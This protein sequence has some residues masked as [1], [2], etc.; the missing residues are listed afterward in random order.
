M[1]H[2]SGSELDID[3]L[4][5]LINITPNKI[6]KKGELRRSNNPTKGIWDNSGL[7]SVVSEAEFN[8]LTKQIEEVI[9]YIKSNRESF[10]H[11]SSYP[12]VD[13]KLFDFGIERRDVP[14]QCDYFPPELVTLAGKYGF[15]IELSQYWPCND[16]S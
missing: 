15:G 9:S 16:E 4:A 13:Q 14:V 11:M 6:W 5:S 10:E 3:S 2:I 12:G 7:S 1:L 8:E